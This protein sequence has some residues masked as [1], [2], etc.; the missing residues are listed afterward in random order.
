MPTPSHVDHLVKLIDEDEIA[1]L[2][3]E[4]YFS[5]TAPKYLAEKTGIQ[6]VQ[7]APSVGGQKGADTYLEMIHYNLSALRQGWGN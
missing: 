7:L 2:A 1:V 5:G 4:P 3:M 6:V